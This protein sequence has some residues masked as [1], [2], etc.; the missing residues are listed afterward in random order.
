MCILYSHIY[1]HMYPLE[2]H[3]MHPSHSFQQVLFYPFP[4]KRIH[5]DVEKAMFLFL[6]PILFLFLL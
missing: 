2:K 6:S 5:L 3:N 4:A 1:I